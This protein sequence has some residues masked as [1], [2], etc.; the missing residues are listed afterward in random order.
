VLAWEDIPEPVPGPGEL[1]VGVRAVA[2]AW[3][4][5]LEREGRYLGGP[6]PPFTAGHEL[7]GEVV[8]HGSEVSG[9]P[10]G[11]RVCGF[12]PRPGA[13]AERMAAPAAWL[14]PAPDGVSDE[15]AA[16]FLGSFGTADAAAVTMGHLLSGESVLVHAA[17]GGF[18]SAA[19][20]LCR[21]YGAGLI[22][23]TA[24]SSERR[25][26]A[27]AFG[28]DAVA[29]YDDFPNVVLD[30]TRGRGVDLVLESVGGEVLD[31]SLD[32]LVRLGRLVT[33]GASSGQAASRLRLATLWHRS[34]SVGGVH[35]G[36]WLQQ[37]PDLLEP[38]WRRVLDALARGAVRPVVDA[39]F[40]AD[41]VIDAY[42]HLESRSSVGRTVVV[43]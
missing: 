25:A 28:A 10:V 3:A 6:A 19:V 42:R 11:T 2:L 41:G 22:I 13:L 8:A 23:A 33:V 27:H 43:L 37:C 12:L 14:R 31:R 36:D 35:I 32:C 17:V 34:V 26:R 38:S 9:P 20:Q 21:A 15:G 7:C 29:G 16:G 1:L 5:L 24:G 39:T 4:D 30:A 18:G 40:A